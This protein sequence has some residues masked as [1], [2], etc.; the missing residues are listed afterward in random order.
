MPLEHARALAIGTDLLDCY[1][2]ES[3]L[4][5]GGMGVVYLVRNTKTGVAYAVKRSKFTDAKARDSFLA[6]LQTWIDLPPHSHI[7]T[8]RFFRT[9]NEDIT[10]FSD[11]CKGGSLSAWIA[12]GKLRTLTQVH[13]WRSSSPGGFT[14]HISVAW[15]I[16]TLNRP[17]S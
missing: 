1:V 2:V 11:Y 12:G 9:H 10:V 16:R 4:G 14:P 13:M 8:C 15:C 3:K 7:V 17:M 6:E 5:E